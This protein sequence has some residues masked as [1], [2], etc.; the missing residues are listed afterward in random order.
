M[1]TISNDEIFRL[2]ALYETLDRL[3]GSVAKNSEDFLCFFLKEIINQTRSRKGYIFTFKEKNLL[4][5]LT[6]EINHDESMESVR[7]NKTYNVNKAGDWSKA[8]VANKIFVQNYESRLF[9]TRDNEELYEKAIRVCALPLTI[10]DCF[11]VVLVITDKDQDYDSNDIS[12]L[13]LLA[14]PAGNLAWNLRKF[15]ELTIAKENAEKNEQRKISYLNNISHEIKTPVNA[16]AGFAQLL[17]EDDHSSG[18]SKK[19]LDIIL[20]S[21]NELVAII[22]NVCGDIKH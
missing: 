13:E 18:N 1:N 11:T 21:S 14:G 22:N 4:F 2:K 17:K 10:S 19:F 3:V 20:E 5:T 7:N 15:E 9:P 6:K 16:I 12:Y 8:L